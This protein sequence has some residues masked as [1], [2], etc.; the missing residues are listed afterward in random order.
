MPSW[1]WRPAVQP[2][3]HRDVRQPGAPVDLQSPLDVELDGHRDAGRNDYGRQH[4][5][6]SHEFDDI[7]LVERIEEVAVPDIE[8]QRD[9]DIG[10]ARAPP[11][12]R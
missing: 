7:T 9:A 6:E 3:Q 10:D 11:G 4:P 2:A 1:Y 8:P 5:Q 12:R